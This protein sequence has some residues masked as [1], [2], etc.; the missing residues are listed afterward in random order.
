M[1]HSQIVIR[2]RPKYQNSNTWYADYNELQQY[3]SFDANTNVANTADG[4]QITFSRKALFNGTGTYNSGTQTITCSSANWKTNEWRWFTLLDAK[5]NRYKILSNTANTI[6]LIPPTEITYPGIVDVSSFS[7]RLPMFEIGDLLDIYAWK[8]ANAEFNEVLDEDNLVFVGQI[9]GINERFGNGG[10]QAIITL[11]N[12]T[13]VL[14]KSFNNPKLS[15][16][17]SFQTFIDKIKDYIIEWVN[18]GNKNMINIIWDP[19]NPTLKRDDVTPFPAIDYY[20]DYK[21][22]YEII[23]DLC[24]PK[25]T[26]DGEY[27]FYIKPS[28]DTGTGQPEYLFVLRPKKQFVTANLTEGR[29]F[30]FI[31]RVKDKGDIVTFLVIRCGRDVYNNNVT[32]FV[33]GDQKYGTLGKPVAVNFAGDIMDWEIIKDKEAGNNNFD[34]E[35]PAKLPLPLKNGTGN[36]TTYYSVTAQEAAVFPTKLTA[37]TFTATTK[38]QYNDW[39]RWLA[40][41]KAR[42][43]GQQYLLQNNFVKNKVVVEFY[44]VPI[45]AIPGDLYQ[46]KID[47]IGW[48]DS[49]LGGFNYTKKLRNINRQINVSNKGVTTEVTYEEDWEL[50]E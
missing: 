29:D 18:E 26:E 4:A 48:T 22:N 7:I 1:E 8:V 21:P 16:T 30:R 10:V 19:D 11:E 43:S 24:Q 38:S 3:I 20:T 13:E 33:W 36:Y 37:G 23:A 28:I 49:T 34:N 6:T 25:Y 41:A 9:K 17:G 40:K 46:L 44:N 15:S 27:Y 45:S 35:D 5:N 39:V 47:S 12:I 2:Y 50:S 31:N 42:I 14:F 32:T